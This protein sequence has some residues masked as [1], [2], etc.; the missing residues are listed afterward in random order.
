MRTRE[1]MIASKIDRAFVNQTWIDKWSNTK[2]RLYRRGTSD[3]TLLI[4][5]IRKI[6]DQTK[7][8]RFTNSWLHELGLREIVREA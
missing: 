6:K 3:H 1:N 5:E 2:Y 4:V 8:F 7:P